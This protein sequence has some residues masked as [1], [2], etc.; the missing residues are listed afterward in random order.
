MA[1]TKE[2]LKARFEELKAE[3]A[4]RQAAV[5]GLK[6]QRDNLIDQHEAIRIQME[7]LSADITKGLGHDY[8]SLCTETNTVARALGAVSVT[9]AK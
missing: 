9:E 7:R 2:L 4:R 3:K 8:L 1:T 6:D 5:K